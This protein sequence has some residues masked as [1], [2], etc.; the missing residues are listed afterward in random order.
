MTY[1]VHI[2]EEMGAKPFERC[3]AAMRLT[4]E[5]DTAERTETGVYASFI[6]YSGAMSLHCYLSAAEL[7]R[8]AVAFS[9]AAERLDA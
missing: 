4:S 6:V 8:L 9:D 2:D 3:A 5:P 1:V 7:R